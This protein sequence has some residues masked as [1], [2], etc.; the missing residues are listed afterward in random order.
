MTNPTIE[1][2]IKE[3]IETVL[4]EKDLATFEATVVFVLRQFGISLYNQGQ[5]DALGEVEKGIRF[6][7]QG[8]HY[9]M[10]YN[11]DGEGEAVG[12]PNHPT[13][14][15]AQHDRTCEDILSHIASLKEKV[16]K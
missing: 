8:M 13:A 14:E 12:V 11:A 7:E 10:Q 3:A 4:R 2:D 1:R 15:D 9:E 16:T 6:S 5:M